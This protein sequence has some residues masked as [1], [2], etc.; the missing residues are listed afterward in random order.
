MRRSADFSRSVFLR[1]FVAFFTHLQTLGKQQIFRT[2]PISGLGNSGEMASEG[3]NI[4][5]RA[6]AL[7]SAA[8]RPVQTHEGGEVRE[9]IEGVCVRRYICDTLP[10]KFTA[11][12][13]AAAV[14]TWIATS[15]SFESIRMR[16]TRRRVGRS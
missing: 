15:G 5:W 1:G 9:F 12:I 6:A 4:G 2:V 7:N 13:A 3:R 16:N 14:Q 11:D 8:V 10:N